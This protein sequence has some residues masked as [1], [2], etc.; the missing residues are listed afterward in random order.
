M[1]RTLPA[2]YPAVIAAAGP[3]QVGLSVVV[4]VYRGAATVATLV[5]ALS[6]LQPAGGIEIVLVNDGSPDASDAECRSLLREATVPLIYIEHA[7]NYGEHNAVMTGLRHA[8]GALC[9]HHGR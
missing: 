9:H 6:A 1:N 4:P 3:A 7:R 2:A 8:S 5:R